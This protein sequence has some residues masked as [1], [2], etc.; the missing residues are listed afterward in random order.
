MIHCKIYIH[1]K[2]LAHLT[3]FDLQ[4]TGT[5]IELSTNLPGNRAR[6]ISE[7]QKSIREHNV[8]VVT[9]ASRKS[10][11]YEIQYKPRW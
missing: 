4:L 9:M 6:W 7:V 1:H 10:L 8:P 5:L 2:S 3:S 11:L